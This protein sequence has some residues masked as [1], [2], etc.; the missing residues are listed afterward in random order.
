M[1][2]KSGYSGKELNNMVRQIYRFFLGT[3]AHCKLVPPNKK[4]KITEDFSD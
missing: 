1:H 2:S 3:I 4:E